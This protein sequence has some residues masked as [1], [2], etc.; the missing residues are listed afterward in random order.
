[1]FYA[2]CLSGAVNINSVHHEF[3]PFYL[4]YIRAQK[5]HERLANT[6]QRNLRRK[7]KELW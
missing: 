3:I 6:A 1:M 5:N 4:R 7:D 2:I